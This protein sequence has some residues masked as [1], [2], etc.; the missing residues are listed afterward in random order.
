MIRQ[1]KLLE[2]L[3]EYSLQINID[4]MLQNAQF[5]NPGEWIAGDFY[6]P[7]IFLNEVNLWEV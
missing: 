2:R 1:G 4:K 3:G 5:T 6:S 7:T